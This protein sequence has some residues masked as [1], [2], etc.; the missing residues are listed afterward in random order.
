LAKLPDYELHVAGKRTEETE[1]LEAL[2]KALGVGERVRF[3]G[4]VDDIASF[5]VDIDFFVVASRSEGFPLALQEIVCMEKPIICSDIPLFREIFTEEEVRFFELENIDS[6]VK[7]VDGFEKVGAAY[8][9]KAHERYLSE[10]TPQKMV[11][12]YLKIYKELA[13]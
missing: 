5:I 7:A 4:Y 12:N 13:E 8:A 11:R 10:Y 9:K 6:L 2:A 3:H 1:K